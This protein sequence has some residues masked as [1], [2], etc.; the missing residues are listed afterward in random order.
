MGR[1]R[2]YPSTR[3]N[4]FR[5]LI[6]AALASVALCQRGRDQTICTGLDEG[7]IPTWGCK[8]YTLC[9]D[10]KP[11]EIDCL[12]LVFNEEKGECDDP[13]NTPPPCG[14][15]IDCRKM[16]D[17]QYPDLDDQCRSYY[18][19]KDNEFKGHNPCAEGLV[20]N[21]ELEVCDWPWEVPPPCGTR[22]F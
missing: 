3:L 17:G 10:G 6:A 13:K 22:P 19:C 7:A 4:M 18:T 12:G 9:R 20:Y 11:V 1:Y 15:S 5:I 14:S 16:E 21:G 2:S 8:A